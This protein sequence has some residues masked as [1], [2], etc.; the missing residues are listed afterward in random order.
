MP[1]RGDGGPTPEP[2]ETPDFRLGFCV[3]AQIGGRV[4][5]RA[6]AP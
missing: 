6:A 1:R 5:R 3:R 4:P 2:L